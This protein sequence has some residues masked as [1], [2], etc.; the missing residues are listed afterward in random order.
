MRPKGVGSVQRGVS[1]AAAV[2][3]VLVTVE[4]K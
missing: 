1:A 2:V 3:D 4:R